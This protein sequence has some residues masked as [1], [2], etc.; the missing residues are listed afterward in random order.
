[1]AAYGARRSKLDE[2]S[3]WCERKTRPWCGGGPRHQPKT[4]SRE[5][6]QPPDQLSI[7][8]LGHTQGWCFA[9]TSGLSGGLVV[10]FLCS[11]NN[12]LPCS[13]AGLE[14]SAMLLSLLLMCED[15]WEP[16]GSTLGCFQ[17]Y[18]ADKRGP[19][20]RLTSISLLPHVTCQLDT[21]GKRGPQL[22]YRLHWIGISIGHFLTH[23]LL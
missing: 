11:W 4:T 19:W 14:L 1:M 20:D 5:L 13:T 16:P 22:R 8:L 10:W 23:Y 15:M 6:Q 2:P 21:P 3:N 7:A 12:A 9:F 18:N 17:V